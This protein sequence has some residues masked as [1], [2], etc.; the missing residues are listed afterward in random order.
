M[1]N[2]E[3]QTPQPLTLINLFKII[4]LLQISDED[5]NKYKKINNLKIF[6]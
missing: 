5:A 1:I 3:K 4:W 2:A 6:H